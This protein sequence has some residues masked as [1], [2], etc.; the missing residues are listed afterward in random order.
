MFLNVF[1]EWWDGKR[2]WVIILTLTFSL[3][4]KRCGQRSHGWYMKSVCVLP[5]IWTHPPVEYTHRS[6]TQAGNDER[7]LGVAGQAGHTAVRSCRDVLVDTSKHTNQHCRFVKKPAMLP[8][9][10]QRSFHAK[11]SLNS[12]IMCS[13]YCW[14]VWSWTEHQYAA[15]GEAGPFV[16]VLSPSILTMISTLRTIRCV[17]PRGKK[18]KWKPQ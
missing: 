7:A 2:S 4:R 8:L 11:P 6:V 18:K 14:L 12:L 16:L 10:L 1:E 13:V 5:F 17:K 9:S 15:T 3:I